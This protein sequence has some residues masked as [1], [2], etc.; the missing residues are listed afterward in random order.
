M[1]EREPPRFYGVRTQ[2]D[3]QGLY[4]YR[5]PTTWEADSIADGRDGMTYVPDPADP[6]SA[7]TAWIEDLGERVVAEDLEDLRSGLDEG[8]SRLA[9]CRVESAT[10]VVIGDLIKFERVIAFREDGVTRKRKQ[11]IMYVDHYL[12]VLSWQ[13][14]TEE[15]YDYWLAMA[16]YSFATFEI[17]HALMFATD[18]ELQATL[19]LSPPSP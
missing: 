19:N 11:M 3:R 14:S 12:I 13:G 10:E 15:E 17:S 6:H 1:T 5:V 4:S 9:D 18:R 7:F 8:L 16:S 2:R